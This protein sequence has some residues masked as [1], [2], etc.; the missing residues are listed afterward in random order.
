M[1]IP[2]ASPSFLSLRYSP[3]S[4]WLVL[5][6]DVLSFV[7]HRQRRQPQSADMKLRTYTYSTNSFTPDHRRLPPVTME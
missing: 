5:L 1:L 3:W 6:T 2:S 7:L 4:C